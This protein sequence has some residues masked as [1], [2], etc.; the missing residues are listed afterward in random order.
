MRTSVFAS[1]FLHITARTCTYVRTTHH[2]MAYSS[3][4]LVP[5]KKKHI[6]FVKKPPSEA[7]VH[8]STM[9]TY[10]QSLQTGRARGLLAIRRDRQ[11]VRYL[12]I[13]K[14]T[15]D[16]IFGAVLRIFM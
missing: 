7:A 12:R 1:L 14:D 9:Y 15:T 6:S 2:A 4:Q 8:T 3:Q 11:R 13:C 5:Q 16:P 10:S